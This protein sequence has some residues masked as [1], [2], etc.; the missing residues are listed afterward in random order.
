MMEKER[1]K[2]ENETKTNEEEEEEEE[3]S[4]KYVCGFFF[5]FLHQFIFLITK[6]RLVMKEEGKARAHIHK[7]IK[8]GLNAHCWKQPHSADGSLILG[9]QIS[10]RKPSFSSNREFQQANCKMIANNTKLPKPRGT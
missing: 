10:R 3:E 6:T 1:K 5:F 7:N 8:E 2:E 9:V 4:T